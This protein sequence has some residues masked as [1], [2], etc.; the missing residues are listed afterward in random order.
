M[1]DYLVF[2]YKLWSIPPRPP[3][4]SLLWLSP[5]SRG[6]GNNRE[7]TRKGQ[8]KKPGT[9]KNELWRLTSNPLIFPRHFP[10]G[11]PVRYKFLNP[12]DKNAHTSWCHKLQGGG[13]LQ[14]FVCPGNTAPFVIFCEMWNSKVKE[15]VDFSSFSA[16]HPGRWNVGIHLG[17]EVRGLFEMPWKTP[18]SFQSAS[19][20][21]L[22]QDAASAVSLSDGNPE[23]IRSNLG[24]LHLCLFLPLVNPWPTVKS[25]LLPIAGPFHL[26]SPLALC[27]QKEI[28]TTKKDRGWN[29]RRDGTWWKATQIEW[30]WWRRRRQ[31][32]QQRWMDG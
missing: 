19:A 1:M 3:T 13:S 32:W 31:R 28:G 29:K 24:W 4:L 20:G 18:P 26:S 9:Q 17:G 21:L 30:W 11:L 8:R 22:C 25:A 6:S 12:V 23:T 2:Y 27:K 15:W 14:A 7:R 10:C 16:T 5:F